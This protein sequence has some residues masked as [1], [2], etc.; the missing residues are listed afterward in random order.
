MKELSKK[1]AYIK[2]MMEGMSLDQ[3]SGEAKILAQMLDV[4]DAMNEE[5]C[6]LVDAHNELVDQVDDIDEDLSELEEDFYDDED[7]D[8]DDDD[9]FFFDDDE[10]DFCICP[11]C[12]ED[13][14]FEEAINDNG[15]LVCPN[16]NAPIPLECDM[17]CDC[18]GCDCEE[19]DDED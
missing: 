18:C 3:N 5:I 7:D 14:Y 2:G 4:L 1:I 8:D 13:F 9:D 10:D 6:E 16:C 11:E 12:G 17:D 19:V 15:D